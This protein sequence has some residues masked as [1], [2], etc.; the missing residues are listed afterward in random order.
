MRLLQANEVYDA[1]RTPTNFTREETEPPRFTVGQEVVVR[2][3]NPRGHTRLP[4]YAKGR[5][6]VIERHHGCFVFPDTMA[7]GKG[8]HP[9]HLYNVRF[10]LTELFGDHDGNAADTVYIDMWE[11]YLD[12]VTS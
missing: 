4:R 7:H 5:V 9:Q 1:I 6:G 3:L 12:P 10:T 2:N 8:P 11:S